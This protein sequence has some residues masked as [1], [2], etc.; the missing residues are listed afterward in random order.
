[1]NR[2]H[3]SDCWCEVCGDRVDP[4]PAREHLAELRAAG[5]NVPSVALASGLPEATVRRLR[6]GADPT[7]RSAT[8]AAILAVPLSGVAQLVGQVD[9]TGTHRRI[10]ALMRC[11]WPVA[12]IAARSGLTRTGLYKA[13]GAARVLDGTASAVARAYE[14]LWDAEPDV[15]TPALA[16]AV[17]RTRRTAEAAGWA[18]PAAYDDDDLDNPAA[19]EPVDVAPDEDV[20]VDLD[21]WLFLVRNDEDPERAAARCGVSLA[22]VERAARADKQNRPDVLAELR[23]A[24]A[25]SRRWGVETWAA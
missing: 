10:H 4:T 2:D 25:A 9:A 19:P 8:A 18:P 12:Q 7:I 22:T 17:R 13:L 20:P 14:A 24:R 21:E 11:G 5:L 3:P 1:M 23:G 16:A 15:S 6:A